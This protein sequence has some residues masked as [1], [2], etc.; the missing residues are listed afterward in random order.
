M[1]LAPREWLTEFGL[2]FQANQWW[3]VRPTG[4]PPG[5]RSSHSMAWSDAAGGFY[6]FGGYES[7]LDAGAKG[8]ELVGVECSRAT[9]GQPGGEY[10]NYLNDAYLYLREA[11]GESQSC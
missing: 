6:I 7:N 3:Q 5:P 4:T 10:L 11:K 1:L 2:V 8:S 9:A